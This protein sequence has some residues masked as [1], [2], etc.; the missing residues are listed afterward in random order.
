MSTIDL[1]WPVGFWDNEF[2]L[3]EWPYEIIFDETGGCIVLLSGNLKTTISQNTELE[4]ILTRTVDYT[5]I[6]AHNTDLFYTPTFPT[7]LLPTISLSTDLIRE[8][9]VLT[10]LQSAINL[11]TDFEN[12][13]YQ[14]ILPEIDLQNNIELTSD[15]IL[16][17][18]LSI[19]LKT[20]QAFDIDFCSCEDC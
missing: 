10:N 7:D 6:S 13:V 5:S 16:T 2:P 12:I 4:S 9:T 15:L 3:G 19:D 20:T 1:M 18:N 17:A 11:V 8:T 14:E